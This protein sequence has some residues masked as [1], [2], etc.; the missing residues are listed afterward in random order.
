MD[1]VAYLLAPWSNGKDPDRYIGFRGNSTAI[2]VIT[3][4][5]G[6]VFK[7]LRN[8]LE[9][10]GPWGFQVGSNVTAGLCT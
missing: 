4:M 10:S 3:V 5:N 9:S 8:H 6:P 7:S 2:D 1:I